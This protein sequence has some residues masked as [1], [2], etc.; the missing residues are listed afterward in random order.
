MMGLEPMTFGLEVQRTSNYATPALLIIISN[1]HY[2][3]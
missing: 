1:I 2:L 3:L